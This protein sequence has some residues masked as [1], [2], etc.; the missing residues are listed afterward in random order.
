MSTTAFYAPPDSVRGDTLVLPADEAHHAARVLR[1]G[2]GDEITVVDGAGGWYRVRLEAVSPNAAHGTVL[3]RRAGRGEP[4]YELTVGL[5][6][7][8]QRGRYETFLEKAVELGVRRIVPLLTRRTEKPKLR[9]ARAEGILVAAMKQCGRSRLPDLLDPTPLDEVSARVA[10]DLTLVCHEATDPEASLAK[11]VSRH[12]DARRI[13][14]LVGPEGGFTDDEVAAAAASGAEVVSLGRRRLR[15]ETA[16][17]AAAAG[18]M[19]LR[20]G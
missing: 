17:L 3:E 16:A 14:V 7:L 12:S 13:T 11:A 18:V 15:A 10:A 9:Q 8:K 20:D 19:L 2:P 6:L 1:H 4:P 5:A